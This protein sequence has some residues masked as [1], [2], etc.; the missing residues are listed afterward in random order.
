MFWILTRQVRAHV[1]TAVRNRL[2]A[3]VIGRTAGC[4][5]MAA[6]A[7]RRSCSQRG[8]VTGRHPRYTRRRSKW[9]ANRRAG[10]PSSR[11]KRMVACSCAPS[12]GV[13]AGARGLT[14]RGK[15]RYQPRNAIAAEVVGITGRVRA[16][17]QDLQCSA[18]RAL[19]KASTSAAALTC[20]SSPRSVCCAA[21][22]GNTPALCPGRAIRAGVAT[23]AR[24]RADSCGLCCERLGCPVG[25]HVW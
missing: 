9:H 21:R 1:E 10:R 11:G 18:D 4:L 22:T 25:H 3:D 24:P 15:G 16:V 17:E 6:G 7:A 5:R 8:R 19:M 23:G 14:R 13:T 12:G 20:S 2:A